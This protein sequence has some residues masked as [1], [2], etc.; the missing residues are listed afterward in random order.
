VKSPANLELRGVL[1]QSCLNAKQYDCAL[2]QY[3]QILTANPDS[4]QA[5]MLLGEA[6]DGL[7]LREQAIAE[8]QA[9]E[10][11]APGEPNVH[12]GLGYLLWAQRQDADAAAEFQAELKNN[13]SHAQ[14]LT[15]LADVDIR[16]SH[17]EAAVPLLEKAIQIDP[18]L[19]LAHL[20]LG[21]LY[22]DADRQNDALRELKVAAKLAPE[23]VNVHWRLGRLYRA[24]GKKEEAKAEFDK[25]SGIT[26]AADN[27]LIDKMNGAHAQPAQAPQPA[28]PAEK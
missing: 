19:A 1:A 17:P 21:I 11:A 10:K 23:D 24:M 26:K 28:A 5:H 9:A 4:A 15:Y 7:K 6:L 14:A 18:G 16:M 8:F 3:R 12:F 27:A 22:A 2:E 13:P 25:A 20:D